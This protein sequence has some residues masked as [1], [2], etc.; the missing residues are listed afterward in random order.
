MG[1]TRYTL[2]YCGL[3]PE[4]MTVLE[5]SYEDPYF[6]TPANWK[7][8]LL[9]LK[10]FK[11]TPDAKI[12]LYAEINREDAR[13]FELYGPVENLFC[14]QP[15]YLDIKEEDASKFAKLLQ[16]QLHREVSIE[17]CDPTQKEGK[18]DHGRYM[19]IKYLDENNEEQEVTV[20]FDKGLAFL[21][22]VKNRTH[23]FGD[24]AQFCYSGNYSFACKKWRKD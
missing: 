15:I 18:L 6:H 19:G 22:F 21:D 12:Q 7:T 20:I 2:S 3:N 16:T 4:Q 14:S 9:L 23:L 13:V 8:L 5:I 1:T 24:Y 17:Y 10:E 11:F